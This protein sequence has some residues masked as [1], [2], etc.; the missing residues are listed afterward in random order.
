MQSEQP[1]WPESKTAQPYSTG[2]P[3]LSA[4]SEPQFSISAWPFG[5]ALVNRPPTGQITE[6]I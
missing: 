2:Q 3:T 1:V 6:E 5:I 4:G